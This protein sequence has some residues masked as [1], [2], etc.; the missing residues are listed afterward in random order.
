MGVNDL[1]MVR[2]I[3]A[4]PH[5]PGEHHHHRV[6]GESKRQSSLCVPSILPPEL[7]TTAT[8]NIDDGGSSLMFSRPS[9]AIVDSKH[10]TRI[11]NEAFQVEIFL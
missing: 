6:A 1:P 5:E 4:V 3:E 2:T 9:I 7:M 10:D 11:V 8:F